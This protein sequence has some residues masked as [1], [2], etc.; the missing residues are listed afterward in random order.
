MLRMYVM[1]RQTKWKEY[2]HM[3][4]FAYNNGYQASAKMSS[5]KILYGK[6]CTTPIS[7]DSLVDRLI[8]GPEMLQDM[9]QTVWEL[10][11]NLKVA[12]N[13]QKSHTNLNKQHKEFFVGD[14]V[15]LRVKHK[16]APLNWKVVPN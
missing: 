14:H 13:H 15:Y 7:W 8:V 11:K 5:F 2:L 6:K 16:R 9:E 12:Q 1:E 3:V 4:D 10:P